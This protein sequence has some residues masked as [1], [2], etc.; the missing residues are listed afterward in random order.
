MD[1]AQAVQVARLLKNLLEYSEGAK[2]LD[3][4]IPA[5]KHNKASVDGHDFLLGN[6]N[7]GGTKSGRLSSSKVNLQTLPSTGTLWAKPVKG[8]VI[9]PKGWIYVGADFNALESV[10]AALLSRDPNMM[11]VFTDG[12]DGH[13][14]RAHAYFNEQMPDINAELKQEN[15][16]R[17]AIINSI[18]KR[19]P[20]LRQA[21]KSP[22][23]ALQYGSTAPGLEKNFGFS[24]P[25][26]KNLF[27]RFH[28]LYAVYDKYVRTK[29]D[30]AGKLG[31][32]ELAFGLR[33]RTPL[34][35]ASVLNSSTVLHAV[36]KDE[37]SVGNALGQSY[38]LL[39]TRA[40]NEFMQRVW[41]SDYRYDIRPCAQIHD[42]QYYLIRNR[43]DCL[44]WVN[45][46]LIQ[47][48]QWCDL[49]ELQHPQIKLGAELEVY[50]PSWADP[51]R[52]P[53]NAT[54]AEIV[55]ISER[56]KRVP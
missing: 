31:Y 34:L 3:T 21:G 55:A 18:A 29:L 35:K 49:P 22:T 46:N 6:F 30:E 13:C 23:F 12:Y 36:H 47:C 44:H 16:D 1:R 8:T 56:T 41:A 17:P 45:T 53:N 37:K 25:E 51:I 5:F 10:I 38:G 54:V 50:F 19:Y 7:L 28:E 42:A 14:M 32:A 33:L 2:I 4:F 39:N 27:D 48:M 20:K 24:T 9:A 40:A 26:A 15:A 43:A 52:I 11:A